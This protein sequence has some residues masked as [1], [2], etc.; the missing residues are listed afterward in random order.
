MLDWREFLSCPAYLINLNSRPERL[1]SSLG[2]L[3]GAG[4]TQVRRWEAVDAAAADLDPLVAHHG[5]GEAIDV[6]GFL[7]RQ[8]AHACLLSHLAVLEEAI[9]CGHDIVHVFEDDILFPSYWST[10]AEAF[11][12]ATPRHWNLLFMGSQIEFSHLP[13]LN[14]ARILGKC[15]R[16]FPAFPAFSRPRWLTC[17]VLQLPVFCTHAYSLTRRGCLA[18][19]GWLTRQKHRYGYDF[20]LYD[21]M[22][23]H[24]RVTPLPLPWYAWNS[25]R[26]FPA[27]ETRGR[28]IHWIRRNTGLVFQQEEFGSDIAQR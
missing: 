15:Q 5:L 2:A 1:R 7:L 22:R 13:A 23:R 4:F 11:Y 8:G 26:L 6:D 3:E 14:S 24:P 27:D 20:M 18:L 21:G 10:H 19:Y 12:Q 28:S 9:R 16:T 17:D 25:M